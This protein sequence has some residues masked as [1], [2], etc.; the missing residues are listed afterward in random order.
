M[1]LVSAYY[2][3]PSKRPP[4]HYDYFMRLFF[5]SIKAPLLFFTD[6]ESHATLQSIAGPNVKFVLQEFNQLQVLQDFP[7]TFW[8]AQIAK[9]PEKYHS[10]QLIALWA[11]K[12][13]FVRKAKEITPDHDWYMWVDAGSIRKPEWIPQ[14]SLCGLRDTLPTEPGVYCQLLHK[15]PKDRDVFQYPDQYIAGACILFH[16]DYIEKYIRAYNQTLIEYDKAGHCCSMDQYIMATAALKNSWIQ[17]I[18][19]KDLLT[20]KCPDDWFFFLAVY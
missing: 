20:L 7:Q 5:T 18:H 1:L 17:L 12:K 2:K 9:D 15:I 19:V 8:E 6:S 11:N 16:K 14:A 10:W 13:Y 4:E 3:I